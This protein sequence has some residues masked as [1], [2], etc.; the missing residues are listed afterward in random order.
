M[1]ARDVAKCPPMHGQSQHQKELSSPN[2]G[3]AEEESFAPLLGCCVSLW[4][5]CSVVTHE[6]CVGELCIVS[7]HHLCGR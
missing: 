3:S 4:L 1:E 2:V 6:L 7:C 5:I